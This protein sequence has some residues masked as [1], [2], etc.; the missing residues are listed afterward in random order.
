MKNAAFLIV[1]LLFLSA[2]KDDNQL[3]NEISKID[4]NVTIERFDLVYADA[5]PKDLPKLKQEYPFLFSERIPDS[6]WVERMQDTLQHELSGEVKSTFSNFGKEEDAIVSLFQHLKYYD[7]SFKV[8]RVI[9][10]TSDV[11]YRNKTIVTDTIVLIS[12]D[13]YLGSEHHF[14]EGIQKFLT[15]NMKRSQIVSDLAANYAEQY[16]LQDKPTTLLDDMVYF[17]KQLYFKDKMIPFASDAD[18]IG[19]TEAQLAWAGENESEIWRYFIE[20]ELL[21]STDN[22]LA[23]RFIADAPF[24]KFYLE[25]D[26]E[27]PGRLGRY[28][29][30]QIVRAYMNTNDVPFM[31]MLQKNADE[32]FNNSKFKPRK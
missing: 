5:E 15:Q 2:C 21:F 28:I 17:G 11:D 7:R 1:L 20:R 27:S 18:K 19:Y 25:L 31:E 24:S 23:S 14:Y 22:T 30:W 26:S 29:G 8:P 10:V 13:T 9:T 16:I 12:L 32:I 3:E 6:I 4:V